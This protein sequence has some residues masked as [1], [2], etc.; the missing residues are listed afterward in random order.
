MMNK[1]LKLCV[2]ASAVLFAREDV[3][4]RINKVAADDDYI[5]ANIQ[6]ALSREDEIIAHN[7]AWDEDSE[8]DEAAYEIVA[9]L[10]FNLGDWF[11]SPSFYDEEKAEKLIKKINK[12]GNKL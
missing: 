7:E 4:E 2:F 1:L 5:L 3:T 10:T 8:M 11:A 6:S 12:K 9:T